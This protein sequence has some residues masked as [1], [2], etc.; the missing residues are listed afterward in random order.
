MDGAGVMMV[1]FFG[2]R[3]GG[4]DMDC[5]TYNTAYKTRNSWNVSGLNAHLYYLSSWFLRRQPSHHHT[6]G[7][8]G[9]HEVVVTSPFNNTQT[10][11]RVGWKEQNA[12][13]NS[14]KNTNTMPAANQH[15][16]SRLEDP[17]HPWLMASSSSAEFDSYHVASNKHA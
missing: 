10:R 2:C 14:Q 6:G 12:Y 15:T 3:N 4:V 9:R 16:A 1:F 8:D 7:V 11:L 17:C 5:I 13:L